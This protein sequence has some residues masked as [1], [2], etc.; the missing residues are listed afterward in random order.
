MKHNLLYFCYP[1]RG[2]SLI[3]NINELTAHWN[4]FDGVKIL[5][6]AVDKNS[7]PQ[8]SIISMLK[9][10]GIFNDENL[11]FFFVPNDPKIRETAHFLRM[12]SE[13]KKRMDP[14]S[15]TFFAHSKGINS[16]KKEPEALKMWMRNMWS[17]NTSNIPDIDKIFKKGYEFCGAFQYTHPYGDIKVQWHYS[18]TYFW[19]SPAVF[20][21]RWNHIEQSRWGVESYPA[22]ISLLEKAFCINQNNPNDLYNI[23]TWKKLK[24]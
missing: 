23:E 18:G 19:F 24:Y 14:D 12:L 13:V 9:Y 22:T 8:S 10:I 5:F 16:I 3:D 15:I 17:V 7:M 11:E 6:F 1:M 21:K 20:Q 4:A 2:Q